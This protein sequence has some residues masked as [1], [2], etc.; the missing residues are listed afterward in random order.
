[1]LSPVGLKEAALDSP[2]FRS[3]FTHFSE[4]LD[5]VERWLEGYARCTSKLTHEM[6]NFETLVNGFLPQTTPP[7]H[8]AEAVI[9]H[10]Y[11]LLAIKIYC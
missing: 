5:L 2:T 10:D 11:T 8:L 9:D 6:E 3:G 1:M 7:T 4:H